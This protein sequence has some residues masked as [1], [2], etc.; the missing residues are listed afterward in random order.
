[1]EIIIEVHVLSLEFFSTLETPLV[2]VAALPAGVVCM[3]QLAAT[4]SVAVAVAG[5]PVRLVNKLN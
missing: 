3:F 1:M 2:L 4:V 5:S